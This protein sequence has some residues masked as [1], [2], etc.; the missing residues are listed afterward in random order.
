MKNNPSKNLIVESSVGLVLIGIVI[1]ILNPMHFWMPDMAH[2]TAL[3][4]L[5]VVFVLYASFILREKA[6]DERDVLHRMLAARAAFFTGTALLTLGVFFGAL[7][8]DIDMWLV[9]SLVGMILAKLAARYYA[10]QNL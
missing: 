7:K 2:V 9:I 10:D 8:G 4:L 5:L 6:R 3:T 1:L